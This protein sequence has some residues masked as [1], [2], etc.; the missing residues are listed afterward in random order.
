[1]AID[2]TGLAALLRE[3]SLEMTGKD[4]PALLEAKPA[5]APGTRINVTYLGNEDLPMRVAASRA[6]LDNGFTP[7]PHISARRLHSQDELVEFLDALQG[8]DVSA[9]VFSV[10][11]DPNPPFGPYSEAL[12]V[13]ET[14]LLQQHGVQH[15]SIAGYP[16]GHPDIPTD[17]LWRAMTAKYAALNAAGL[18]TTVLTQFLFDVDAAVRWI[19]EVREH[20]VDSLLRIGVPGPTSVAKLIRFATRFGVGANAMI[21]KKYGFS[22]ANLVGSAGPDRFVSELAERLTPEHGA[23]GLHF[24]TF[25]GLAATAEWIRDFQE[26]TSK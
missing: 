6:V 7:V 8:A 12:Q 14:G 11:G 21:V 9:S 15:V 5:I 25:G 18:G 13:I 19:E 24:Y 23:V 10:G 3:P 17:E 1:M 2:T 22:L 16:E 20:G 4:I 26:K